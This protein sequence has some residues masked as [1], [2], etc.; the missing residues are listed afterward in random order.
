MDE[1]LIQR[2]KSAVCHYEVLDIN[3][4]ASEADIKKAYP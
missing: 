4:D 3:H 2:I 1:G